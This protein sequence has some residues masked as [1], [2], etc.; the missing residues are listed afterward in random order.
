MNDDEFISMNN[1]KY[2]QESRNIW[3]L[4]DHL[5]L[6]YHGFGGVSMKSVDF[7]TP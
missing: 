2:L 1:Q 5:P 4:D 7:E 3:Y 6:D